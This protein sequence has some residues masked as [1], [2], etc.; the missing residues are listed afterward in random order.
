MSRLELDPEIHLV[1]MK[2]FG[3]RYLLT[4]EAT[5]GTKTNGNITQTTYDARLYEESKRMVWR[6]D[7]Q[8]NL[9]APVLEDRGSAEL[10]HELLIKLNADGVTR[11]CADRVRPVPVEEPHT[12]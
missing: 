9:G 2:S 4:L 3:S 7:M 12:L 11:R 8:L 10:A 6:A 1:R 5:G